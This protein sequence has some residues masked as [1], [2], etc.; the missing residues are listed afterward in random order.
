MGT[1]GTQKSLPILNEGLEMN[2]TPEKL[3]AD[4]KAS[5]VSITVDGPDLVLEG[6]HEPPPELLAELKEHKPEL[7]ALL[8]HQPAA[9]NPCE[10]QPPNLPR[11]DYSGNPCPACGKASRCPACGQCRGC[12]ER[13][14]IEGF[15]TGENQ[16]IAAENLAR[17]VKDPR[18]F[19]QAVEAM[20]ATTDPA[21]ASQHD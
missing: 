20:M 1:V 15:H 11:A 7:L 19:A 8:S 2:T 17:L 9:A 21:E 4:L 6:E 13:A 14:W 18:R 3:L 5:G 12:T 16:R 10:C